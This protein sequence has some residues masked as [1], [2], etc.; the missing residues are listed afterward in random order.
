[1]ATKNI[2]RGK[3]DATGTATDD[4]SVVV[5]VDNEAKKEAI[6]SDI[7]DDIDSHLATVKNLLFL[8]R[9]ERWI[10]VILFNGKARAIAFN[11]PLSSGS[12]KK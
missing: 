2:R 5:E 7:I 1:M 10:A 6:D 11:V 4:D 9:R 12:L 8:S 3:K